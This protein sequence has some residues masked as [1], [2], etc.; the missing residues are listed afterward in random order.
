MYGL[1]DDTINT[2]KLSFCEKYSIKPENINLF[3]ENERIDTN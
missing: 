1:Y 3:Y 2:F